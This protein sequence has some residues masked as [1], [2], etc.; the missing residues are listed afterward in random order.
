MG[1]PPDRVV[2][3]RIVKSHGTRGEVVIES[4]TDA[5]E[6]FRAGA[7]LQAMT[8]DGSSSRRMTVRSVRND[9]GRLLVRFA[10]TPDRTAA[11]TMRGLLLTIAGDAAAPLPDG[12]YYAWQLE[13][14]AV[15]DENGEG[16]GTLARVEHGA[17]SD[18]WIVDADGREVLV[19]AVPEFVREVDLESR[20][21]VIHVIPGLFG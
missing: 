20:R 12:E 5:P 18:L 17:A 11:D 15:F 2:V 19:P 1:G 7:R 10:E 16:L 13:G 3:G 4:L 9:R 14:L 6:R 8:P 21:I